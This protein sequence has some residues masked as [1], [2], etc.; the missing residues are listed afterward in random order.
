MSA[1]ARRRSA[2][3]ARRL[4]V[5]GDDAPMV[6]LHVDVLRS[7]GDR[8]L[9]GNAKAALQEEAIATAA[10]VGD[11]RVLVH[12]MANAVPHELP[13]HAVSMAL[14]MLLPH[15]RCRPAVSGNRLPDALVEGLLRRHQKVFHVF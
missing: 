14:A 10:I 2:R 12:L 13:D 11:L 15:W 5:A 1:S 3:S 9:D 4:P 8:R 6:L 7:H